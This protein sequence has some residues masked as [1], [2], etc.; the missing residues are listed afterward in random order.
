MAANEGTTGAGPC[1][2]CLS[3][4]MASIPLC[5]CLFVGP[6]LSRMTR[7]T[8]VFSGIFFYS[9]GFWSNTIYQKYY[10]FPQRLLNSLNEGSD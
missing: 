1:A 9:C 8:R 6:G 7:V 2:H 5:G 10:T 4:I 3:A